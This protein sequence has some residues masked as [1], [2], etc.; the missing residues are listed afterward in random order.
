M[1]AVALHRDALVVD[2]HADILCDV[3][4][5]RRARETAVL[6][7]RH[8][9]RL[10]AGGFGAVVFAVYLTPYL[11]E[12]ALRESLLMI[13]DLRQEIA[14]SED[15][16]YLARAAQDL[17]PDVRR[18]RLAAL[19]SLEGAEPLGTDL[20]ILR[21]LYDLG[22]RALGLTWF[23][24][25][26]V[27]DGTGEEEAGGGLT[28]FGRAV[29]RECHRLGILVDVS[30]LSER[31]FWDVMRVAEGPVI[32]SHS[33]A[34]ALCEHPRNLRDEQLRALAET[35]GVVGLNACPDFVDPCAPSLDRLLDHAAHMSEVMGPRHV[36]LG[37]DLLEYLPG[38]EDK[39]LPGL[40]DASE[41]PAI[42][43]GLLARGA[44][45]GETRGL[46]GENWL[47]V[48]RQVLP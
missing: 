10:R 44:S 37:L 28:R 27:A 5:R 16:I 39:R 1:D 6:R 22:L 19:L 35:G 48:W 43:A 7:R 34:R 45:D 17:A 14:E 25:T 32:A 47:R 24:R 2:A 36:G 15:E 23:R 40:A 11:P 3:H 41:A 13:D 21:L 4:V 9:P 12:I 29:V 26:M 8:L 38:Y 33:N 30:H 20:G 46:L 18:G 42:T 31:G